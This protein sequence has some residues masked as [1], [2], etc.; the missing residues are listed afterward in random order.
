M[1]AALQG[2]SIYRLKKSWALVKKKQNA[3]LERLMQV[4][5][6]E[7]N[8]KAY[9]EMLHSCDPPCVPYLGTYLTDL[10]FISDGNP[11]RL[12]ENDKLINWQR[13]SSMAA[14]VMEIKQ[15]ASTPYCLVPIAM[16]Q[17]MFDSLPSLDDAELH[18]M[19]LAHEPRQPRN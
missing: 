18:A 13:L 8:S 2:A 16:C 3:V 17:E 5:S 9:R 10:T 12:P 14:I 4:I 7:H 1:C 6:R 19:S 15:F 11:K